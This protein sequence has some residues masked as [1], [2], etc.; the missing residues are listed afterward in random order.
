MIDKNAGLCKGCLKNQ[1][2][3]II[4]YKVTKNK[5]DNKNKHI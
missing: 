3:L 1:S 4:R 2:S 5:K